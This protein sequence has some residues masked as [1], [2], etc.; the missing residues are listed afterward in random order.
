MAHILDL[1][2][3]VAAPVQQP[4]VAPQAYYNTYYWACVTVAVFLFCSEIGNN[5]LLL[6][7]QV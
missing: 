4:A 7:T 1:P 2:T 5:H 6:P 3:T